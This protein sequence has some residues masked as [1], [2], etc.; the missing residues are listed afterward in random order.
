MVQGHD[1]TSL[2]FFMC[3]EI[4]CLLFGI[5]VILYPTMHECLPLEHLG[6]ESY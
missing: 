1:F 2:L 4:S 3:N 6:L 5:F